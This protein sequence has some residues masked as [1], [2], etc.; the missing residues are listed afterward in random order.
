MLA[1]SDAT[2]R[3]VQ[4]SGSGLD[5]KFDDFKFGI[6]KWMLV[7]IVLQ[8]IVILGTL[9]SLLHNGGKM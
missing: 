2:S 8:T 6:I 4:K 1:N 9:I 7:A 3:K 5:A